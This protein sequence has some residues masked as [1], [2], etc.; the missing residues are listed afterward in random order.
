[1]LQ[2]IL[3]PAGILGSMGIL[4][5]A[6][7]AFASK[8]LAVDVDERIERIRDCLPGAGCG[9]CGYA[10]C[11]A[12]AAAVV[13][14]GAPVNAC[15]VGG[16][17]TAQ[18]IAQIMGV[19]AT[20]G[21]RLV[22]TVLC[23]GDSEHC[24]K[25]FEYEGLMECRAMFLTSGG[26]KAC[27]YACLGLGSCAR[28]CEFDA[29]TVTDRLVHIDHDKCVGCGKCMEVCPKSVMRMEP[30]NLRSILRCRA[31]EKGREVRE[32]CTKGCI[33]CGKCE[34]SCKFG[35]ITM[36]NN[37]PVID[38]E[39]CVGCLECVQHCPTGAITGDLANRKHAVIHEQDCIGCTLC[40]RQ[41]QFDAIS[42]AVKQKHTIDVSKCVGCGLC[43]T[44]CPKKCI[45]M[46]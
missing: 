10:G 25:K 3:L 17:S 44:K 42:G 19:T 45:E 40:T 4:F 9:A 21:T 31:V 13:N 8:K 1:M 7:L 36:E 2:E 6:G 22:A 46:V 37:L 34:R 32:A 5:G 26:D 12:F 39:K 33:T 27:K 15:T 20:E 28:V 30:Y 18:N 16:A 41:C 14:E 38:M 35:A 43:A 29:I 11:D 24:K 23:Q